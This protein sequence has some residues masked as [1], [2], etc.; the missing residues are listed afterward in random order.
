MKRSGSAARNGD[1]YEDNALTYRILTSKRAGL[2]RGL[3]PGK[4]NLAWVANSATLIS[5]DGMRC[6]STRS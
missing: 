1:P 6:W 3:P 2:S 4:E 5:G